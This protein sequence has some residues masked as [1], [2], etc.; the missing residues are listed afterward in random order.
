M[1]RTEKYELIKLVATV[2]G[3]TVALCGSTAVAVTHRNQRVI[4]RIKREQKFDEQ[5]WKAEID[6]CQR[7]ITLKHTRDHEPYQ[8]ILESRGKESGE[9]GGLENEEEKK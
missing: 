4:S 6:R 9:A 1:Q 2:V 7:N 5:V 3:T 8:A